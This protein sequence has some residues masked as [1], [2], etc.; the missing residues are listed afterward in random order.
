MTWLLLEVFLLSAVIS[1][2]TPGSLA[3]DE[4]SQTAVSALL[5]SIASYDEVRAVKGG[6]EGRA[7]RVRD[8]TGGEG[9]IP[10][11]LH[12]TRP[13]QTTH[14]HTL[15]HQH[16]HSYNHKHRPTTQPQLS[17]HIDPTTNP[18]IY[19]PTNPP[20]LFSQNTQPP[21]NQYP[22]PHPKPDA[23]GGGAGST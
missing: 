5:R 10:P 23:A 12:T 21:P 22:T 4:D 20:P 11:N 8:R 3:R 2:M 16:T 19:H 1:S 14:S 15:N 6:E 7:R 9:S 18:S 13:D 17:S